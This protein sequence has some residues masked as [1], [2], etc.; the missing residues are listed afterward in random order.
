MAHIDL[1]DVGKSNRIYS[2]EEA[3]VISS[4][5]KE[6]QEHLHQ[7]MLNS[8]AITPCKKDSKRRRIALSKTE[9]E[10]Q[11]ILDRIAG[12]M[13]AL[14]PHKKLPEDIL[15]I[16]FTFSSPTIGTPAHPESLPKSSLLKSALSGAVLRW[17]QWSCGT[18]IDSKK[19]AASLNIFSRYCSQEPVTPLSLLLAIFLWDITES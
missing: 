17:I 2:D 9:I 15:R 10:E 1:S 12:Y 11:M 6:A 5:L 3:H 8:P 18:I 14:A 19:L 13:V 7:I 16:I 4:R